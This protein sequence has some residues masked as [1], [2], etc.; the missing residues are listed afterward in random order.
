MSRCARRPLR[1]VL[2]GIGF[3]EGCL[4]PTTLVGLQQRQIIV[5]LL[6]AIVLLRST[7]IFSLAED[8]KYKILFSLKFLV[9]EWGLEPQTR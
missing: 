3:V 1:A 5:T 7:K 9:G 6:I 4:V 8:L 2:V